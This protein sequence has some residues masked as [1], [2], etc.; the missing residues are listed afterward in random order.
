MP[1]LA[2][3]QG[4]GSSVLCKEGRAGDQR[5]DATLSDPP[6]CHLFGSADAFARGCWQRQE[7]KSY[8]ASPPASPPDRPMVR[9][10]QRETINAVCPS[11][12]S[13][14]WLRWC[15]AST[16]DRPMARQTKP[17]PRSITQ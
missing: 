2:V 9:Q 6:A 8:T 17:L 4:M 12:V 3:L 14:L 11:Y 5:D 1:L 7:R 15:R 16:P 13:S 10:H